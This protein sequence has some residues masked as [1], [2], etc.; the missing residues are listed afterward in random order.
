MLI[1][2][3]E[4]LSG[5]V[6]TLVD[7]AMLVVFELPMLPSKGCCDTTYQVLLNFL[8][9][10]SEAKCTFQLSRT[11]DQLVWVSKSYS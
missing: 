9:L 1:L 5:K 6:S 7:P 11:F 4:Y 2:N 10:A 8:V 3:H